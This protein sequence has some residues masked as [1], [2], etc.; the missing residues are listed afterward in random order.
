MSRAQVNNRNDMTTYSLEET[1]KAWLSSFFHHALS[2]DLANSLANTPINHLGALLHGEVE[3][4]K[5]WLKTRW[6]TITD[7]FPSTIVAKELSDKYGKEI[8]IHI[9]L[10]TKEEK[11]YEYFVIPW[12]NIDQMMEEW[13]KV[14]HIAYKFSDDVESRKHIE[15]LISHMKENEFTLWYSGVNT[16]QNNGKGATTI[17]LIK[18]LGEDFQLKVEIIA[19]GLYPEFIEYITKLFI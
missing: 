8:P 2:A 6:Y 12:D 9:F 13:G 14:L 15:K 19:D 10:C 16:Q 17:Y 5:K 11:T 3:E 1:H 7:S 18:K 4:I